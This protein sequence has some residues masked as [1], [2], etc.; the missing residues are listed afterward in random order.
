MQETRHC[1]QDCLEMQASQAEKSLQGGIPQAG[2]LEH[3]HILLQ[4]LQHHSHL[5]AASST[6]GHRAV[7]AC[8]GPFNLRTVQVNLLGWIKDTRTPQFQTPKYAA[9]LATSRVAR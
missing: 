3:L 5:L 1:S 9:H 4:H 2:S 8:T 6:E 7:G